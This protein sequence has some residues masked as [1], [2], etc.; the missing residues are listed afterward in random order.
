MKV[1]VASHKLL[2]RLPLLETVQLLSGPLNRRHTIVHNFSK[3]GGQRLLARLHA[4][5]D[6]IVAFTNKFLLV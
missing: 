1:D 3:N 2:V 5:V 6:V 4:V